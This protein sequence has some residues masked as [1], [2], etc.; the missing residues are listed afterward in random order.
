V[1]RL[2]GLLVI[3]CACGGETTAPPPPAPTVAPGTV[4]RV[5][6]EAIAPV[7]VARIAHAQRVPPREALERALH[8]AVMAT[9]A[10]ADVPREAERAAARVLARVLLVELGEERRRAPIDDDELERATR[11]RWTR[12]DRP[13]GWRT[14]HAVVQLDDKRKPGDAERARAVAARLHEAAE[15]LEPELRAL[16]LPVRDEEA[17]FLFEKAQDDPIADRFREAVKAVDRQGLNVQVQVL[18]PIASD[19]R[20]IEHGGSPDG[21]YDARFAAAASALG[22]RGD[23]SGVIESGCG[24]ESGQD[25]WHVIVLLERTPEK[26]VPREERLEILREDILRA[27]TRRAERALLQRLTAETVVEVPTNADALLKLVRTSEGAS[28]VARDG[29]P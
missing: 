25:C 24:A 15:A 5:G 4:A 22:E 14:V 18:P 23:V 8:D 17:Q 21:T 2:G 16:P 1:R 13:E 28:A 6:D 20:V 10:R 29:R 3:A 11:Y 19:G 26:R 7:T 12:V 27:R 9:A